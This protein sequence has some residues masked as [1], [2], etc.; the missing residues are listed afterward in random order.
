M[1]QTQ[2]QRKSRGRRT[3]VAAV[4]ATLATV[5]VAEDQIVK[6]AVSVKKAK[7]S[8][9]PIVATVDADT[10]LAILGRE[11]SFVKVQ[12]PQGAVGYILDD[13]L[14]KVGKP[15]SGG[16]SVPV[17]PKYGGAGKGL[18]DEAVRY[19]SDKNISPDTVKAVNDLKELGDSVSD[20]SLQKF[21]ADQ[22]LGPQEYRH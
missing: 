22:H 20:E 13:D 18:T 1:S 9:A 14:P 16:N 5:A 21:A 15:V 8:M 11:G 19:A 10:K 12:T 3:L 17:N 7:S 4:L 2:Q 6:H